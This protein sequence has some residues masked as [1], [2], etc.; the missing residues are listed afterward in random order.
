MKPK[1]TL[2]TLFA[3]TDG[4]STTGTFSLSNEWFESAVDFIRIDRGIVVKVW[5]IEVSGAAVDV[6]IEYTHDVTVATPTYTALKV[7]RLASEGELAHDKRR[8]LIAVKGKTGKEAVRFTWSQA[9]AA[10][11]YIAITVEFTEPQ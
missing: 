1:G 3:E 2:L 11:S 10:K 7:V 4:T 8:P 6:A 5:G 9:T